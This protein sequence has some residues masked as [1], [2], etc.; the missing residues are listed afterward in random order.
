MPVRPPAMSHHALNERRRQRWMKALWM[1]AC[2]VAVYAVPAFLLR[3]L[4][5]QQV[6]AL[7]AFVF[8]EL[9][10]ILSVSRMGSALDDVDARAMN[11]DGP[12]DLLPNLPAAAAAVDADHGNLRW[13]DIALEGRHARTERSG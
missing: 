2:L 12:R 8:L 11:E 5:V 6:M 1:M 10:I 9:L 7:T 3:H 4:R 13:A